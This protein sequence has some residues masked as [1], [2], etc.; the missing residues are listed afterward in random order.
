MIPRLAILLSWLLLACDEGGSACA[1]ADYSECGTAL[2]AQQPNG[3]AWPTYDEALAA[4]LQCATGSGGTRSG[5]VLRGECADGKQFIT[6]AAA[7]GGATRFYVNGNL[8]GISSYTDV[9]GEP[10][11][12]PFSS[13]QGTLDTVRC[14]QPMYESLCGSP[15]LEAFQPS[16]TSESGC[17]CD[18]RSGY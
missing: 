13:F 10:C 15:R 9:G 14:D 2:P 18:D 5:S 7:F 8:V 3:V 17:E 1:R 6:S 11:Q 4:V 12:C 16:F